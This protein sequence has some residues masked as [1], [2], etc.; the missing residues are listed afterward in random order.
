MNSTYIK[1]RQH[2]AALVISLL[3]LAI[4]SI[5]AVTMSQTSTLE[6]RMAGNARDVNLAFQASDAGLRGGEVRTN[7]SSNASLGLGDQTLP[8]NDMTQC[9]STKRDAFD[10]VNFP[11]KADDSSWWEA[12]GV[13]YGAPSVK[14]LQE[15][16]EDPEYLVTER[17]V[18]VDSLSK[19]S[20]NSKV[21]FYEV[22][23]RSV[24]RSDKTSKINQG[25]YAA[26]P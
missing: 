15:L 16:A 22:T 24:G 8:C 10:G 20:K 13:E 5:L 26:R 19:S 9:I 25:I 7:P 2:G 23:S 12:N 3:L 17:G 4:M 6:E 11:A 14:D 21:Y 18:A 1:R